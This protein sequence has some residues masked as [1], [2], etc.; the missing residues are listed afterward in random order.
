V[1]V[2]D[3]NGDTHALSP[4]TQLVFSFET[5]EAR[6]EGAQFNPPDEALF[7]QQAAAL[8]LQPLL[9]GIPE[10]SSDGGLL[11][12]TDGEWSASP[13]PAFAYRWQ[14][15]CSSFDLDAACTDITGATQSTYT[16]SEADCPAVRVVVTARNEH[17][18]DDAASL[19]FDLDILGIDCASA[20]TTAST[21]ATGV[22]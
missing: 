17:G 19:P 7:A 15:V 12:A 13:T 5:G 21:G 6:I 2:I 10:L 20:G 14:G 18:S 8:G 3:P 11:I 22:S 4:D 16:P 1:K 9:R